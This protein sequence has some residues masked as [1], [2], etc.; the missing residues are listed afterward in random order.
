MH[1]FAAFLITIALVSSF[2][3]LKKVD[4]SEITLRVGPDGT[5]ITQ[6]IKPLT[7][8]QK[9]NLVKQTYDYSCGSAALATILNYQLGENLS[10]RQVIQGLLK[11]GDSEK[12]VQRRAFSLL[13]MKR[14]VKALG[15]KGAGY[16]AKMKDLE[17]LKGPGIIP[18]TIFGY[19]H[20]TVFKGIA[21]GHV[22]L[23]DPWRGNLSFTRTDFLKFWPDNILFLVSS[24]GQQDLTALKLGDEDLRFIDEDAA[25]TILFN[26]TPDP[27][28]IEP[29][30]KI[31]DDI[32]GR[33]QKYKR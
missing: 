22:I 15:Y 24:K 23:A 17:T 33:R 14:F 3:P 28:K 32:P 26:P 19:K 27:L 8:I 16:K 11:Y 30:D 29:H 31:Y 9:D 5:K 2:F 12:I 10:E 21:K 20:F 25:L 7:E 4:Q 6:N 1:I 13:D 18:I